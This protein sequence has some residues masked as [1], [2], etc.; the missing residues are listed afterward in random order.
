MAQP[1]RVFHGPRKPAQP[2][3]ARPTGANHKV[4]KHDGPFHVGH[5]ASNGARHGGEAEELL[6]ALPQHGGRHGGGREVTRPPAAIAPRSARKV[7]RK[8]TAPQMQTDRQAI[9]RVAGE[10]PRAIPIRIRGAHKERVE[11]QLERIRQA[12]ARLQSTA[13]LG[14]ERERRAAGEDMLREYLALDAVPDSD[15]V[16]ELARLLGWQP[17]ALATWLRSQYAP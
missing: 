15:A 13:Q 2:A 9:H 10:G 8:A 4:A 17:E 7:A 5:R 6:H 3:P 1:L 12:S 14:A 16:A 11:A